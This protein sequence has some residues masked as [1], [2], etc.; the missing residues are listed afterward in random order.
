MKKY[1]AAFCLLAVTSVIIAAGAAAVKKVA[2]VDQ[3]KCIRCGTC[4][5]NCPAKAIIRTEMNGTLIK[6]VVDPKKCTACGICVALCPVKA[7][8]LVPDTAKAETAAKPK[9]KKEAHAPAPKPA[10]ADTA[11]PAAAP[12]N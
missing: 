10:P 1:L 11:K 6:V 5:K 3:S 9:S 8:T 12:K 2:F 4:A 7:I